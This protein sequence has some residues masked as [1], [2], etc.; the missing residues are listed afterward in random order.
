MVSGAFHDPAWH[1]FP[2]DAAKVPW[3]EAANRWRAGGPVVE[4][5]QSQRVVLDLLQMDDDAVLDSP[6][7]VLRWRL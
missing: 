4:V 7:P 6:L 5:Y 3:R 1:G 2:I